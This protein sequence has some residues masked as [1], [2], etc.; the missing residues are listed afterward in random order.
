MSAV[1]RLPDP[2]RLRAGMS[3]VRARAAQLNA[4]PQ[5]RQQALSTL[6]S[7][8]QAGRSTAAAVALANGQLRRSG[9]RSL[10]GAR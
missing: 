4:C 8:M 1:I 9:P 6:L 7:E 2:I 10:G 5:E 3:A